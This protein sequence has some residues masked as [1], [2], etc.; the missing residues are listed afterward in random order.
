MFTAYVIV[1]ILAA[2]ANLSFAALDFSRSEWVIGNMTA[3]G[4]PPS[5]L[6][7]LGALKAA[8]GVGILVGIAVA[9]IGVAAAVGLTL[10][11]VGAIATHL[12]AH[13]GNLQY[14]GGFLA[15]AVASLAL[16]LASL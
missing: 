14:P 12:R 6:F 9:P 4:L 8:G 11:F 16:Q 5:S 3:V 1:T 13:V 15:L 2:A 10:F 7:P